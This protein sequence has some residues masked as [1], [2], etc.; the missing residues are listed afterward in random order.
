[1]GYVTH[2]EEVLV[3]SD[4]YRNGLIQLFTDIRSKFG[5]GS[6]HLYDLLK[7][8]SGTKQEL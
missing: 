3:I 7:K 4:H 2:S 5:F 6:V 8:I 1:M